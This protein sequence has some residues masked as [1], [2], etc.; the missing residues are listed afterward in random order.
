MKK[1]LVAV[2]IAGVACLDA[3]SGCSFLKRTE[4]DAPGLLMGVQPPQHG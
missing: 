3:P 2:L 1:R 4:G